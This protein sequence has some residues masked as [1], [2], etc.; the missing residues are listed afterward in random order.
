[1]I[2]NYTDE[3]I[4]VLEGLDPVKKR[5]GM[6]IGSTDVYGLHHLIWEIFDN[7][8]DEVLSGNA[9]LITIT[10]K[11]DKSIIVQDNGRGIPTGFNATSKLSTVDTVFTVLH[12]GG[13]FDDKAYR[14]SGGLHGVGASVVNALSEWMT[15]K[16]FKNRT[17]WESQYYDGGKIKQPLKE[18]GKTN[19]TGTTVH[20]K[21]NYNIF[22]NAIFNPSMIK[23]RVREATYIFKG[24]KVV[25]KNEIDDT[26]DEFYSKDGIAQ[27]VEF[28]DDTKNVLHKVASFSGEKDN[29]SIDIALQYSD[30]ASSLIISFANS[31]KTKEG[32]SHETAF[33]VAL[34]ESINEYA[35]KNKLLKDKDKNF[36]G[37]DVREGLTAVISVMVPESIIAY[38]GQTKNKLFTQEAYGAVKKFFSDQFGFWLAENKKQA[39]EIIDKALLARDARVAAKKAREEVKKLKDSSK[40]TLALSG[41]LTPAQSKDPV[42]NEIFLVEG[43]SAGGSAKLARDKKHQAILPL[44]G[45]VINVEKASLVD[46]LS[47]EEISTIILTL[48]TDISDNFEIANLKYHKVIIMTDADTDGAHIQVLLLTFFYRFMRELIE[49]GH[50]YIALAPLYKISN[51]ITKQSAYAWDELEL[52]KLKQEF[53]SYTIQR[54]KGLGEMNADQLKETT[55][56]S[57]TRRMIQVTIDDAALAERRVNTLMGENAAKRKEWIDENIDFSLGE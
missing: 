15:V 10:L 57:N 46:L 34:T 35:R 33:K 53:K 26:I 4:K 24:L 43:D 31:V 37:N 50:V 47:N 14:S 16:V 27:Y 17:I 51:K 55:M 36:E 41:K 44:R 56:N 20:F 21:P 18:I 2:T 40:K 42:N 38:E 11:K 49:K 13:K 23:E 3:N 22:K 52:E 29:I 48:G 54:Y 39:I 30:D 25:F 9:D 19:L 5:P 8:V 1:M 7:S 28:I 32:G 12:A 45:K 6:Y